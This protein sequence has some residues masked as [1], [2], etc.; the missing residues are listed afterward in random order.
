MV[1]S[2]TEAKRSTHRVLH[3][4]ESLKDVETEREG[5][6]ASFAASNL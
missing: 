5:T 3:Y 2:N 4:L 1:Y 6:R